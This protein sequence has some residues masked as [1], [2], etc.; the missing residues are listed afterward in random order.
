MRP[1]F[2]ERLLVLG[3]PTALLLQVAHPLVA[4]GVTDHSDYQSNA[5]ARL[6]GTLQ[7]TLTVT[8]GD[9]AQARDVAA[10][11]GR[12]HA[13]VTGALTED[14]GAHRAGARYDATDP[15]LGLWVHSTL[16]W[17]GLQV[18][19]RYKQPIDDTT[20][21]ALW[22]QAKPFA[23]AFGV[24]DHTIPAD[25]AAFTDYFNDTL[26]TLHVGPAA[27][28][29]AADVLHARLS[30][31]V[32]GAGH[33]ARVI[34]TDLLPPP[35]AAAYQLRRTGLTGA[36]IRA[37]RTLVRTTRALLPDRAAHWPHAAVAHRRLT[38]TPAPPTPAAAADV[39]GIEGA[40]ST[41]TATAGPVTPT[42]Q[43]FPSASRIASTA[44]PANLTQVSKTG[45]AQ[46]PAPG[47]SARRT[48]RSRRQ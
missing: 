17:T 3:G 7:A 34:T 42:G 11:I 32:P 44:Y 29:I 23:H 26:A 43:R 35:L 27:R 10:A 24:P 38:A 15:A 25:W 13:P 5:G 18:Y 40:S 36:E 2:S 16:M 28:A 31:P 14:A 4:A 20:R 46:P 6:T 45:S 12:R 8:F 33:L 21:D 19:D 22:Q 48:R 1:I 47:A 41:S 30:P 37:A 39:P 9:T